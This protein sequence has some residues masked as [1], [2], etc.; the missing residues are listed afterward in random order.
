MHDN[1]LDEVDLR[2]LAALQDHGRLT[3]SEL[4]ERINLSPSQC[5]RRRAA[6]EAAGIITGYRAELSAE[7]L[8]FGLLVFISVS[9]SAHSD[10][11]AERFRELV[12][13]VAEIQEAH[14]LTGDND[15]LLKAVLPD[16]RSL[17]RLVNGV[18]LSH[19]SV[20]RVRS[21]IVLE[22]LKEARQLPLRVAAR[23]A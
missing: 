4:G 17:S 20:A 6:L 12:A 1:G 9:L 11:N 22:R 5:S 18:L 23:G 15:Y 2:L 16:L 10:D 21:S 14:A 7:A 13:R 3:N 19:A 8:G